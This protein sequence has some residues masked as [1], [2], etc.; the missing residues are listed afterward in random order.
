[1]NSKKNYL[2]VMKEKPAWLIIIVL[3]LV[4]FSLPFLLQSPAF[5][6]QRDEYLYYEQGLHPSAGY[7][8]NPPLLSYLG[9]ISSW[10]GGELSVRFWPSLIGTITL[11]FTCLITFEFGG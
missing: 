7:L 5:E 2:P 9:M 6:L 4:K 8:E 3:S 10:I 1:M 11:I